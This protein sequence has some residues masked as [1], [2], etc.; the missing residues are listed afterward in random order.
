MTTQEQLLIEELL[1]NRTLRLEIARQN[2]LWFFNLYLSHY[3]KWPTADFQKEFFCVTE[4]EKRAVIVAFRNSGKSSV[5]T[6]SFPIWAIIGKLNRKFVLIL[7]Q[8]QSQAQKHLANI[9][10]LLETKP[11]LKNDFGPFEG[12][13]EQWAR[14]TLILPKYNAQIMAASVEQSIRGIRFGENRPDLIICDD[15]EDINSVKTREGREKTF[16]WFNSEVQ[17]IGDMDTRLF[18][19]GNLLH[20]DSLIMRLKQMINEKQY[21]ATYRAYPL[22]NEDNVCIWPGKFPSQQQID[23]ERKSYPP[24][25]FQRE[26]LLNIIP[27]CEQIIK[28]EWIK[29]YDVLPSG[30]NYKTVVGLDFAFTNKESSDYT[31]MIPIRI[32]GSQKEMKIYILP[33]I[34]NRKIDFTEQI[35]LIKFLDKSLIKPTFYMEENGGQNAII[36]I[37]KQDFISI[38][39]KH[40]S[41]DKTARLS[42][43]SNLFSEGTILFPEKGAEELINQIINLGAEKHDDLVDALTI[44]AHIIIEKNSRRVRVFAGNPIHEAQARWREEYSRRFQ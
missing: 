36:N 35:N 28:K 37:L 38:E 8:T 18:V 33:N 13:T 30:G 15:V 20:E 2:H 25:D 11:L 26:F 24:R 41:I 5:F 14:D 17:P 40:V 39:S 4:T 43:V 10:L 27:G 32:Y 29:H 3:V 23:D 31:A 21:N 7:S 1:K 22:L 44:A 42:L 12:N 34:V 19:I 9:R 6:T 16:Q